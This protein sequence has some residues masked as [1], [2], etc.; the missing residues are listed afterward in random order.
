MSVLNNGYRGN[1][2]AGKMD[3]IEPLIKSLRAL[4]ARDR[5]IASQ[6]NS[7]RCGICYL[8]FPQSELVYREEEGFYICDA[9]ARALGNTRMN[10]VRRQQR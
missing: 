4:F 1:A 2:E 6:P 3:E 8:Y 7:A 9:C 10:M 5:A